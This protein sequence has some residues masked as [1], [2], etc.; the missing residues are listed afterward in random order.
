VFGQHLLDQLLGA[1]YFA[2][3]KVFQHH[4]QDVQKLVSVIF[5]N[6]TF[7]VMR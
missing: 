6:D 4:S 3:S 1:A 5:D 2:A 7:G